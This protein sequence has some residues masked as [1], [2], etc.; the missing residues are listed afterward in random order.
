MLLEE[1]MVWILLGIVQIGVMFWFINL[2]SNVVKRK[3]E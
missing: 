3:N 2:I 1:L